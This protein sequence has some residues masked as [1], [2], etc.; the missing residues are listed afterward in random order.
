MKKIVRYVD[1]DTLEIMEKVI[2]DGVSEV[3]ELKN[4]VDEVVALFEQALGDYDAEEF[5]HRYMEL[6]KAQKA[7]D[8]VYEPFKANL[9]DLHE[10]HPD[11]PKSVVVGTAKL[12]YVSP[13]TR[14]SIDSKKLKEEEPAIAEKYSKTTNVKASIRL[15]D[16]I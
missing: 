6:K 2:D 4:K 9:I 11:V 8:E 16:E 13:S 14:T 1:E 7:F 5:S 15:S 12:T 3:D 10:K